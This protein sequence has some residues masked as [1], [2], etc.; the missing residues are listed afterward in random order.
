MDYDYDVECLECDWIGRSGDELTDDTCPHCHA[1]VQR[2]EPAHE[3][4]S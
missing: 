2:L 4:T 1:P 3:A